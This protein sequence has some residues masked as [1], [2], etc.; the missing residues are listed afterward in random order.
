MLLETDD[1]DA[2]MAE[3]RTAVPEGWVLLG[4]RSSAGPLGPS[5]ADLPTF[6][7]LPEPWSLRGNSSL[8][9]ASSIDEPLNRFM[10]GQVAVRQ[11]EDLTIQCLKLVRAISNS[12]VLSEHGPATLASGFDPLFISNALCVV[13]EYVS[14]SVSKP[15]I[16]LSAL[17]RTRPRGRDP[18][19]T[20][21]AE[22]RR[23]S[24][25]MAT[26][27]SYSSAMAVIGSPACHKDE[28]ASTGTLDSLSTGAPQPKRGS[29]TTSAP[30]Y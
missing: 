23:A 10:D 28:S 14:D 29:I 13:R 17:A 25:T 30:R 21:A 8:D 1:Y 19:R 27:S 15:A 18:G 11:A 5:P 22:P 3:V 16:P 9:R 7:D 6:V 2:G 20:Q 4:V 12:L 26:G 24:S